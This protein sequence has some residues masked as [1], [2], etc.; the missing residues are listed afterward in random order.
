[1]KKV[2]GILRLV[3][4]IIILALIYFPENARTLS[5]MIGVILGIAITGL[6]IFLIFIR[7]GG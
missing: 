3:L 5:S 7:K 4:L 1:M 2:G 6:S